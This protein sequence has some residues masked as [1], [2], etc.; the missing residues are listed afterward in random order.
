MHQMNNECICII[1]ILCIT[2]LHRASCSPSTKPHGYLRARIPFP[3]TC[4]LSRLPTTANGISLCVQNNTCLD[5]HRALQVFVL[6]SRSFSHWMQPHSH[7]RRD[8]GRSG[9]HWQ[10]APPW[11]MLNVHKLFVY[12]CTRLVTI[13]WSTEINLTLLLQCMWNVMFWVDLVIVVGF[14]AVF[15]YFEAVW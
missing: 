15:T 7:Q 10:Q 13:Y 9:F 12:A 8:T 1:L 4:T 3:C 14:V 5:C 11:P 2:Y 6:V